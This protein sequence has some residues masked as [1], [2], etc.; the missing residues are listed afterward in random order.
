[1]I[2][3]A[4][5]IRHWHV[6]ITGYMRRTSKVKTCVKWNEQR[7]L[8]ALLKFR[9]ASV[10][11][12]FSSHICEA[13]LC[14]V[15]LDS[16]NHLT[17]K[18]RGLTVTDIISTIQRLQIDPFPDTFSLFFIGKKMQQLIFF[19]KKIRNFSRVTDYYVI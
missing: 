10:W 13:G 11:T 5:W 2:D 1:M 6:R 12:T 18:I 14:E 16:L 7:P 9:S 8:V 3:N 17:K 15:S 19:K 4:H